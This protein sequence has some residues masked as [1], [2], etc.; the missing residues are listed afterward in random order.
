VG[1]PAQGVTVEIVD[2]NDE[3][4]EPGIIG[5]IRVRKSTMA[6]GY[7]AERVQA[8]N[9]DDG[10]FYPRDLISWNKDEP[11]IF[12]GR[13]DDVMIIDGINVY[14]SAIEDILETHPDVAEAV[15]Y[16]INSRVHGQI[17]VA[18]VILKDSVRLTDT[19]PLMDLCRGTLGIRAP[20]QIF[21][22]HEIPR[23]AAGKP[24]RYE[25]A[26]SKGCVDQ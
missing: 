26:A 25:L 8:F 9:F 23:N 13:A 16:P 12:H 18:A 10:W 19:A 22:V 20:R 24:L 7:L 5:E 14:A 3:V 21:V 15:A 17:P 11:L 2:D 4:V 1:F 6:K